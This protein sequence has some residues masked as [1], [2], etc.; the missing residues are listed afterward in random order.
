MRVGIDISPL[1]GNRTGVGNYTHYLLRHLLEAEAEFLAFGGAAAGFPP[2]LRHVLQAE[3]DFA[4]HGFSAGLH[5]PARD[6]CEALQHAR[7]LPLPT[8]LLHR[9]WSR[10][11]RPRVDA[12]LGGVDVFHATNY[13]LPPV[14]KAK[15]V[16][17][18]YDLAFLRVPELCSPRIVGP[19][20]RQ[21][22]RFALDADAI[23]T[24]SE[25]TKADIVELLGVPE[26]KVTVAHGAA[27]PAF[28]RMSW[29]EAQ[30]L[31]VRRYGITPPYLLFVSTLEPRKNVAGL[32]QAFALIQHEIPH[33]LAIV[34]REGWME[35]SLAALT[36]ELGITDRV[37]HVG[38]VPDHAAL[39]AFY[40]GADAFVFP[41]FHEG[42]GL[43]VLEALACGCP[44][45]TSDRASLPEV[46]GEAAIYVDPDDADSIAN[47]I[48]RLVNDRE[49]AADLRARG[50]EQARKF[51]WKHCAETTLGVYRSLA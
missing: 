24:C 3:R 22:R 38:Y 41:S 45:I 31:M 35:K 10:L 12:L 43:P 39:P 16:V 46:A 42:F 34:G 9:S 26:A 2:L 29:T 30:E 21:I 20:S 19:F 8:R 27:D 50:L 14:Q 37:R 15:R 36:E 33:V 40:S 28:V 4:F 49:L 5:K 23:L 44:V 32:L 51:S 6:G 47:G 7:H 48:R 18:I 25:A 1:A 13:F 17:T 11:G